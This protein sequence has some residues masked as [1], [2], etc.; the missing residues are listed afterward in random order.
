MKIHNSLKNKIKNMIPSFDPFDVDNLVDYF[1]P[2]SPLPTAT[3]TVTAK[4]IARSIATVPWRGKRTV[5]TA[6]SVLIGKTDNT[7]F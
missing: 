1:G 7:T 3:I 2:R 6:V 4:D 5:Q